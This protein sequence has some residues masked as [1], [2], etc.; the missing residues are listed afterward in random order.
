MNKLEYVIDKELLQRV[1][2]YIGS[3]R[4]EHQAVKIVT[5]IDDIRALKPFDPNT[6]KVPNEHLLVKNKVESEKGEG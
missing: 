4:S 5:L 2:D 6:E 3:S 1:L